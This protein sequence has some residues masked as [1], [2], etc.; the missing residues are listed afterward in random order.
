[1]CRSEK[2]NNEELGM[3]MVGMKRTKILG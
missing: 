3:K 2:K 1:M